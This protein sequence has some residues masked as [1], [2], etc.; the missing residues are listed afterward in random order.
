MLQNA[1]GKKGFIKGH[2]QNVQF[3]VIQQKPLQMRSSHLTFNK[4]TTEILTLV[5][6]DW[7]GH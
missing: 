2:P 7:G 1:E 5:T 6:L 3:L 4:Q